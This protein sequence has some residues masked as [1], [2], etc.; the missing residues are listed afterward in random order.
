[1]FSAKGLNQGLPE[2]LGKL[3]ALPVTHFLRSVI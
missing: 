1:M 2:C 3:A